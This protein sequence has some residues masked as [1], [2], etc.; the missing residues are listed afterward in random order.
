MTRTLNRTR[1]R[2]RAAHPTPPRAPRA[3]HA[4]RVR[5]ALAAAAAL[6][7]CAAGC[8]NVPSGGQVITGRPAER[9]ERVDDPYVR[10]IPVPP[11][12]SWGPEEIVSGFLA[13][14]ASFDDD[15]K[16]AKQYLDVQNSWK[17]GMRPYVTVL[18]N[19]I[20][21]PHVVKSSGG[22]A[23]VRV[24]G[25]Q[26]GTISTDGQYTAAP[27]DLEAT[28]QLARTPQGTWRI[29]NLPGEE[30]SGLLL[31]KDDVQRAMHTVN[32]YFF[33]PD[34]RTLVPNGIFLPV[35]NRE[36][37]SARLVRA[38]LAG[39]TSWLHGAVESAFPEGTGLR[40]VSIDKDV[41]VVDLTRQARGGSV[42][43]MSAQL[44]WTL[45]Q[46]SEIK[47]FRLRIDGETTAPAGMDATQPVGGWAGNS[48]DGQNPSQ[49]AN[50]NAYVAGPSRFLGTLAGDHAQPVVTGAAGR[51]SHPVVAPDYRELAGLNDK[52]D[53][54]FTAAP[55]T[56]APG[57]RPLLTA[58]RG[59]RFTA[60][61][62]SRDGTLWTVESKA[63]ES[64][65]W[66]RPRG[67]R[68]VL[69]AHW[70]LGGRQVL[71]FRVARDSVRAA[72]IVKLDNRPQVQIGRI[73][74][75][76]DGSLDVGSF[77]PVSSEMEDAIDLAWRDYQ[78]FAIL[79]RAKHDS[80]SLPYLMPVSGAPISSLGVGALGEPR[81]IAA[82]P[83]APVLIGT[84][85]AEK[86]SV[87]RQRTADKSYSEWI[88]PTAAKDPSY[89][90]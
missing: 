21:D 16:V 36:T 69:A 89:P 33:A 37:L 24:T 76:Q 58:H 52:G 19:R 70:G 10:L 56:G 75:A 79:G 80:R 11:R 77:L 12:P 42:E 38:L 57:V 32:L 43:R 29:T 25:T 6:T 62:W 30:K 13:A 59:A 90:G 87:C 73:A 68:P 1:N 51:L 34:Q 5:P 47:Q 66:V 82:A 2:S 26:L 7:L 64:W 55:V 78:T 23:T 72:V 9:A 27:K 48:P 40:G 3:R 60:P 46:M 4:R 39:P 22:E 54:V 83:G 18:Q 71:A 53:Q 28:F 74:H 81:T 44:A 65:L 15:H 20:L 49:L 8:A 14:S 45:R 67:E 17:P 35:V 41:A 85:S 63:D 86:D 31:T 84:R 88:C 61:S 50:Q